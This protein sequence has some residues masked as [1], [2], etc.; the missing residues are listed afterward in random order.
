VLGVKFEPGLLSAII[1]ASCASFS[2]SFSF[3]SFVL[4]SPMFDYE[5][6]DDDEDDLTIL[7]AAGAGCFHW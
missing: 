7:V 1:G 4:D 2:S 3:S 5:N 6:E